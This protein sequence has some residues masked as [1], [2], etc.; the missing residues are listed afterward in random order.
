MEA[1]KGQVKIKLQ[2]KEYEALFNINA[3]RLACTFLK[4]ELH[5]MNEQLS[6][7][8][9]DVLPAIAYYAIENH[10]HLNGKPL[11]TSEVSFEQF[12]AMLYAEDGALKL[13]SDT[14]TLAMDLS[15]LEEVGDKAAK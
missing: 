13:V 4:I 5:E 12:A 1:L 15:E 9:L 3:F 8:I 10:R 7:K 14:M 6:T 2:K 11:L